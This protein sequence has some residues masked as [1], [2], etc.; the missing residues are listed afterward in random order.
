MSIL[1]NWDRRAGNESMPRSDRSVVRASAGARL[2]LIV[3]SF[4]RLAGK[5]L[6]DLTPSG[7]EEAMWDAPRAIVAYGNE[8]E[9]RLFYANR[10]AIELLAVDANELIGTIANNLV[11]PVL[12]EERSRLIGGLEQHDIVDVYAVVGVAA[13]GRR[14]AISNAQVWNIVDRHGGRHGLG[15]TFAAWQFLDRG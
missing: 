8:P 11:E 2:P 14:F 12:R 9:P 6:V 4:Q 13:N 15:T 3:D 10:I 1:V 5:P 7:F